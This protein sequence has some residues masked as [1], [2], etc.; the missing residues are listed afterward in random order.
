MEKI[1]TSNLAIRKFEICDAGAYFTNN[2]DAQIKKFMPDHWHVDT[3]KAREE[4]QSFISC[5]QDM[6]MPYHFAITKDDI[7]IGH[8]GIGESDIGKGNFEICYAINKNYRGLGYAKE[9]ICAFV[10][11]CKT[12]FGIDK[13]YASINKEN[14][15]SYKS[16]LNAGF[17]L[18]DESNNLYVSS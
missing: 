5:Y 7:L 2:H 14:T 10:P 9:A 8:I 13:L 1:Y 16:L 15:A 3:N 6:K 17:T 11:W 12:T 4:I 18:I